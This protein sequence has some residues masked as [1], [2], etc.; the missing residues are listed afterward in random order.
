VTDEFIPAPI[1]DEPAA[2]PSIWTVEAYPGHLLVGT[3]DA[4]VF[5]HKAPPA[6]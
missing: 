1:P 6:D 5:R 3:W 2:I 4:Y